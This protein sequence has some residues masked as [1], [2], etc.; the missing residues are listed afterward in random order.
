VINAQVGDTVWIETPNGK[1][2]AMHIAGLAHDPVQAP[3]RIDNSPYGYVS[4][5]T[6][7]WF[8]E[9]HGY[10]QLDIIVTNADYKQ[11][12]QRV[13]SEVK[14]KAEKNGLTIP[15]SFAT[16]PGELMLVGGHPGPFLEY[17]IWKIIRMALGKVK[18]YQRE[19][20]EL[21]R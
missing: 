16:E 14:S 12:A 4:F 3:A 10:N 17:V 11:H 5:D 13:L 7:Q 21:A 2:R 20:M 1:Q 15:L 8:G 18:S 9:P 6:V 19:P